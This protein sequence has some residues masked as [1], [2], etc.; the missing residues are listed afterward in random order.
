MSAAASGYRNVLVD[1]KGLVCCVVFLGCRPAAEDDEERRAH[2]LP[3]DEHQRAA[4]RVLRR[5]VSLEDL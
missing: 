1:S 5:H 2:H 3:A 4:G